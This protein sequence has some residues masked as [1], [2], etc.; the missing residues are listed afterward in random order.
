MSNIKP[1]LTGWLSNIIS[2]CFPA[3]TS[4]SW[5]C[6][7]AFLVMGLF[8]NGKLERGVAAPMTEMCES[9]Q[10]KHNEQAFL[11]F[12]PVKTTGVQGDQRTH[13][14]AV[15]LRAVTSQDGMTADWCSGKMDKSFFVVVQPEW[16]GVFILL[17]FQTMIPLILS[18]LNFE[19]MVSC[20][21]A[22]AKPNDLH[23]QFQ[24]Q[25]TKQLDVLHKSVATSVTQQEQQLKGMEDDMQSFVSTK[26]QMRK[27][28]NIKQERTVS[29]FL[30]RCGKPGD[31]GRTRSSEL[32]PE[33]FGFY[34]VKGPRRGIPNKS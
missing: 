23:Q 33:K 4:L 8:L 2:C 1:C 12:F 17:G 25:L 21:G 31:K 29:C 6:G 5:Y 26:D 7:M 18:G 14:N 13:S 10:G 24:T 34:Y 22:A 9:G 27:W 3:A 30:S 28:E 20:Y 19:D 15:T 16:I 32:R 11:V